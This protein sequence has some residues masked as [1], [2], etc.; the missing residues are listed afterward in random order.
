MRQLSGQDATF[1]YLESPGAHLHL[2]ALYLYQQPTRALRFSQISQLIESRLD[3]SPLFGQKLVRPPLDLD[4]PYWVDDPDFDPQRHLLEYSGSIPG[5]LEELYQAMGHLHSL[6][7]DLSRPPWQMHILEK[8]GRLKGF[9]PRCFAVIAKYHHA[10]MDGASG[11]QLVDRLH[12][13][14]ASRGTAAEHA[15]LRNRRVA[16]QPG[17]VELLARAGINNVAGQIKLGQAVASALPSLIKP[18]TQPLLEP[19]G[20]TVRKLAPRSGE[21]HKQRQAKVVS[22]VPKTRFNQPV[23]A[24]RAFSAFSVSLNEVREMRH[25]VA[26]ATIND[27]VLTVCAGGLSLWL[28][29]HHELPD[30]S[31]VAM[32]PVNARSEEDSKLAGNRLSAHFLP[33]HSDISDPLKRLRAVRETTLAAKQPGKGLNPKQAS[34]ISA[35]IAAF[36]LSVAGKLI[37]GLGLNHRLMRPCNCTITNV[38][39]ARSMQYLGP[40]KL[41]F[42]TGSGPILDGM[43]LIITAFSYLDQL[44]FSFT[45]CTKM[46]PDPERLVEC[47]QIAFDQLN[48][49]TTNKS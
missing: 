15:P 46:L 34:A 38:P 36:P 23:S 2:T 39:G 11:T 28:H 42:S 20:Q 30:H 35:N 25:A 21:A 7:L 49:M 17:W 10:A 24:N 6:P 27:V 22:V 40:A 31:L 19:L 18:L 29:E 26:G 43:G 37:T 8:L 4:Y 16:H 32:V 14:A 47:T 1:L 9:P 3:Q 12:S 41:L 44:T 13:P 5:S 45:S 33:I 48:Q